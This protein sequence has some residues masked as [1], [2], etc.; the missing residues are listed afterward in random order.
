MR[1]TFLD[2]HFAFML[3]GVQRILPLLKQQ[4]A[5]ILHHAIYSLG[6]DV[7]MTIESDPRPNS[8]VTIRGALLHNISNGLLNLAVI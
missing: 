5:R 7:N 8:S 4:P 1:V 2:G 3:P 6:V